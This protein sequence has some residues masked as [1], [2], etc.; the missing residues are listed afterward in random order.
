MIDFLF[1]DKDIC[2]YCKDEKIKKHFLC[3]NCLNR[4][5]YVN[6]N[7]KINSYSTFSI[8]FYNKFI[9]NMISDYKFNRNTSL[10]KIFSSLIDEYIFN[11]K[12]IIDDIDY[13]ITVPSSLKTFKNRGFDHIRL[14]F[15]FIVKKYDLIYMQ[16]FKK[17]KDT[18]AQHTLNLEERIVNL[19]DAFYCN[20][21]L[22]NKT[23]LIFDDIITTG[24][25]IRQ[26]IKVLNKCGCDN[27]KILSLASSHKVI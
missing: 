9:A 13:V 7:F 25:T 10:S 4:L 3:E 15:D 6:N 1:L 27:I 5:D 23:V 26:I 20:T 2:Y 8:F 18:K 12:F 21:N 24:N 16:D 19:K 17:I 14:I 22:K 11:N